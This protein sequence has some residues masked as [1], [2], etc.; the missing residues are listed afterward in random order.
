MRR[1]RHATGRAAAG[2]AAGSDGATT[3]TTVAATATTAV[4]TATTAATTATAAKAARTLFTRTRF[5]D[6]DGT[7][8]DRL[9]VHAIDGRLRFGVGTHLHETEALG[10]AG[11]TIHHDLGGRDGAEL[12]KSLEQRIVAHRISQITYVQ[13]VSHGEPSKEP[14]RNH[15][16][17]NPA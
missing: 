9:A 12:R 10:A 6:D 16:E 7:A 2:A 1:R 11:F 5:V 4:A 14:V 3:T 8:V 15:A 17:L 13:F